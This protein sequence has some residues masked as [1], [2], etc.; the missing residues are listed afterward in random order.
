MS[1]D[2]YVSDHDQADAA[3]PAGIAEVLETGVVDPAGLPPDPATGLPPQLCYLVGPCT[4]A[5]PQCPY[6]R[7]RAA[8]SA[9]CAEWFGPAG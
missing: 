7:M 8:P 4:P 2:V 9:A 6:A 1:D 5:A 3:R